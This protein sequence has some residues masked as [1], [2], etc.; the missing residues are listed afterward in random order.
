MTL[1]D[2][3]GLYQYVNDHD[4]GLVCYKPIFVN[5]VD[6][7]RWYLNSLRTPDGSPITYN[8][9][10]G[11]MVEEIQ[12]TVDAYSILVNDLPYMVIYIC[13]YGMQTV[14]Y[15]PKGLRFVPGN[16][17]GTVQQ[18]STPRTSGTAKVRRTMSQKE[19]YDHPAMA[20]LHKEIR[21]ASILT[22]VLAA[23]NCIVQIFLLNN[24]LVLIDVAILVS[25]ALGVQLKQSR[26]CA[27][28]MLIYG[29]INILIVMVLS[30]K[31]GG[32]MILVIGI[33]MVTETFKFHKKWEEYQR[34]GIVPTN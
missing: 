18:Q 32:Y 4:W 34:T 5:G 19:F 17:M 12:K 6:G 7:V 33:T 24:Y 27:I 8:R 26:V 28:V 9:I 11:M 30:G 16:N 22:Y 14:Q 29:C 31:P 13:S 20:K 25:M 23:I 1:N 3:Q 2:G 15:A 21:I 10:G